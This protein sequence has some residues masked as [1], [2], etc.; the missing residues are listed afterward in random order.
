MASGARCINGVALLRA[1]HQADDGAAILAQ[2]DFLQENGRG[3]MRAWANLAV[4]ETFLLHPEVAPPERAMEAV[5]VSLAK[6][7]EH[8]DYPYALNVLRVG[9]LAM[10]RVGRPPEDAGRL[11]AAVQSHAEFLGLQT[12]GLVKP[13]DSWVEEA[14]AGIPV[15]AGTELSWNAMVALLVGD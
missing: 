6:F 2:A 4:A 12:R 8:E 14:L 15:P 7:L 3:F 9:A 13:A 11:L 5:R 1:A 10:V